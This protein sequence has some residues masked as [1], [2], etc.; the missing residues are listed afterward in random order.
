MSVER[1]SVERLSVE[2]SSVERSS[3]ERSSVERS[4][5]E[6][7]WLA[8]PLCRSSQ[9]APTRSL[10]SPPDRC[11]VPIE[12]SRKPA[13]Y[14]P[15]SVLNRR[16]KPLAGSRSPF[17]RF[18]EAE[19][20]ISVSGDVSSFAKASRRDELQ[21]CAPES[22][23]SASGTRWSISN[24]RGFVVDVPSKAEIHRPL[25]GRQ[26]SLVWTGSSDSA[27]RTSYRVLQLSP[28][29]SDQ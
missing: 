25:V 17:D 21:L 26:P 29:T 28:S 23:A 3:V 1:L 13:S 9:R 20:A 10:S 24:D 22:H 8:V 11:S 27:A 4:S 7:S 19:T 18:E 14:V 5:V 6:Q 16:W 12:L 2:R 15:A